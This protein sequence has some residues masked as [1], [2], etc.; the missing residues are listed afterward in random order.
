MA[1][2]PEASAGDERE[3]IGVS[4]SVHR[5]RKGLQQKFAEDGV[6]LTGASTQIGDGDQDR[7]RALGPN[8][9]RAQT[10][11]FDL[12]GGETLQYDVGSTNEVTHQREPLRRRHIR[13][14]ASLRRIEP[15]EE[16][17]CP[18]RFIARPDAHHLRRGSPAGP[19]TLIASAPP[20]TS[21]LAQYAPAMPLDRSRRRSPSS[22]MDISGSVGRASSRR[23]RP[24]VT[25]AI[26]MR[27]RRR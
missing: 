23:G 16:S 4:P 18:R 14:D 9:G 17:A 8:L 27:A 26:R 6:F 25:P 5:A 12:T 21:N 24:K 1:H 10:E 3:P 19:S 2:S 7:L 15:F 20:S 11:G 13:H 22:G